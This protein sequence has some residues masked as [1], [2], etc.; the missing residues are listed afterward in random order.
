MLSLKDTRIRDQQPSRR[1]LLDL[2]DELLDEVVHFLYTDNGS[3]TRDLVPLSTTC[4]RLRK[5]AVPVLFSTLH[6][7]LTWGS[8]DKRTFCILL[9]LN[10]APYSF[11]YHVKQIKND[12]HVSEEHDADKD[13]SL[14]NE[15][16]MGVVTQG[17]QCLV[18]LTTIQSVTKVYAFICFTNLEYS[19]GCRWSPLL[20]LLP[21]LLTRRSFNVDFEAC[22]CSPRN[23]L[24]EIPP[25][26]LA[27]TPIKHR[28]GFST[29]FSIRSWDVVCDSL[30]RSG[31][32]PEDVVAVSWSYSRKLSFGDPLIQN[33][34]LRL[35]TSLYE[36]HLKE[37]SEDDL[38]PDT[39]VDALLALGSLRRLSLVGA[40][41]C[42]AAL[43][44]VSQLTDLESL[45]LNSPMERIFHAHLR[46]H[47]FEGLPYLHLPRLQS[48]EIRYISKYLSI[49]HVV[50]KTIRHLR[51]EYH[52]R[53][54]RLTSFDLR[55]IARHVP[56]LDSLEI[57]TGALANLWHPT[58]VAGVDV[59][60]EVYG[61]LGA[62]SSFKKLRTLRL[63]PSYWQS[64]AGYLHFV[65]PVADEQAVRLFKHIRLQCKQMRL[66]IISNS[67]LDYRTRNNIY[68][69]DLSE[70]VKWV[71]RPSGSRILLTTHQAERNYHLE[72]VWEGDRR[73]TMST[74]RHYGRRLHFD[75]LEYWTLPRYE[76]PF[77]EPKQCY[78]QNTVPPEFFA[79][80][81]ESGTL[82]SR[83]SP[84][85]RLSG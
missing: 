10:L 75:E 2:P 48:L 74:V 33:P 30:V 55:W 12:D 26:L 40:G 51:I 53:N 70:P 44:V 60:M 3:F 24:R 63:F 72:Q 71:V 14:C 39:F 28:I 69:R 18:N 21:R 27:E 29:D 13:L 37:A 62:L 25:Y 54:D 1:V 11:A 34:P 20:V 85:S 79:L 17:L 16:V 6:T 65:Q 67:Y 41:L 68:S 82:C 77:D 78:S 66:L 45:C 56:D 59:D 9:N 32:R 35:F 52:N 15:L 23:S 64:F 42:S 43:S 83:H 7:R 61:M 5:A 19:V 31:H 22:S 80:P 81:A 46:N 50:P 8:I 36:L 76:F 49:E 84:I 38:V 57:N 4:T 47:E 58:A 73:L